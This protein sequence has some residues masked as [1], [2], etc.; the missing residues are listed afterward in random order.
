MAP[1]RNLV[2]NPPVH[3]EDRD[4]DIPLS[5]EQLARISLFSKVKRKP[6]FEETPGAIRLRRI[7]RGEV[8]FRQG[9]AGWTA[10][11]ILTAGDLA[12]LGPE[13][14]TQDPNQNA[15]IQSILRDR[16]LRPTDPETVVSVQIAFPLRV[17]QPQ[18]KSML[19][20]VSD[21]IRGKKS[22]APTKRPTFM[23][24]DA[25]MEASLEQQVAYLSEGEL[26]GEMSCKTGM[27]RSG[28]I[29]AEKD[30]FLLEMLRSILDVIE[31]D[32]GYRGEADRTYKKRVME[33]QLRR[34]SI[35]A[36][37][38]ED[39]MG[40]VKDKVELVSYKVG[41]VICHEN[42]QSDSMYIIR[43]G[44]VQAAKNETDLIGVEDVRDWSLAIKA[45]RDPVNEVVIEAEPVPQGEKNGPYSALGQT[46]ASALGGISDPIL[47]TGNAKQEWAYALNSFIK[48][49]FSDTVK[50]T[51]FPLPGDAALVDFLASLPK[52]PKQWSDK[53]KTSLGRRW[54]EAIH[55]GLLRPIKQKAGLGYIIS[56]LSK[57]E[58][59]GEMGVL[60]GMPR[61]AT[62]IAYVH[63][64]P[65][66]AHQ[67][68]AAKWR[69]DE[70][71][72]ELVKVPKFLFEE[73]I[74][75]S[76]EA[77]L[78]IVEEVTVRAHRDKTV[79]P[80][81]GSQSGN[82]PFSENAEKLGLMQGQRLML[83]D[84]N[85]CTR[86]D[87]CVR[88]CVNTHDDGRSRLYLDGP[89]FGNHLVPATCR[90][91]MDPVCMIGCPVGSIH[92][93]NN[94]QMVI[95]DWC[96]GCG[97][98]VNNCPYGSIQMHDQGIIPE[99]L[100]DWNWVTKT[101]LGVEITA[102]MRTPLVN[103]LEFGLQKERS[104]SLLPH[105][106]TITLERQF[107]VESGVLTQ[108]SLFR[109]SL[110]CPNAPSAVWINGNSLLMDP[111]WG[112]K[113]G[114]REYVV[115]KGEKVIRSGMNRIVATVEGTGKDR[116]VLFDLR[117]DVVYEADLPQGLKV[118]PE[119]TMEVSEKLIR[120]IAVVCDLCS[121]QWGQHPACIN[122]CPHDA[123]IRIVARTD[124]PNL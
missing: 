7:R 111:N 39:Q 118:A 112:Y 99:G 8:L 121:G 64:D 87:E 22:V 65:D 61:S 12:T 100:G 59:L 43:S 60:S 24:I 66:I 123:A 26:L 108:A 62:C 10:M 69:R 46:L 47:L 104:I 90:S 107:E 42:D 122:A 105:K 115:K 14:L 114:R 38:T 51:L 28:T 73:I 58:I 124:L 41:E 56:Y 50:F 67:L 11:Y 70:S 25:P 31:K 63:G 81:A 119:E 27:P 120:Q 32:P 48:N 102:K 21:W 88:A 83:V 77:C 20:K 113:Q 79:T 33:N 92:R 44:L 30:G 36:E 18:T 116:E 96:I 72:V 57:G 95:E 110:T 1:E 101:D 17:N 40:R 97:L 93:G 78:K 89:R 5:G 98:C 103:G 75:Q 117:M 68:R 2:L 23:P 34:L 91:C 52:D 76:P 4:I 109:V 37:L 74:A 35:F 15:L 94:Q 45:F 71:L 3:L 80:L 9:E 19:S 29:R 16:A 53:E 106:G 13:L 85:K 49:P 55:P 82:A 6:K 84:L 54:V 86:C